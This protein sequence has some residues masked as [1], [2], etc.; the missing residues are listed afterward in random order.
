MNQHLFQ[1]LNC[2]FVC[3]SFNYKMSIIINYES[4][5]YVLDAIQG[6]H[7]NETYDRL[8]RIIQHQPTNDVI[9]DKLVKISKMWYYKKRLNCQYSNTLEELIKLF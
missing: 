6:E 9:Y 2:L 1:K 5:S 8:W 4:K 3:F 7:I